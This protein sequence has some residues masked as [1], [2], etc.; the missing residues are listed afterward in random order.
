[1]IRLQKLLAECGIGSRR[2][3]EGFIKEGRIKVGGTLSK[4]GDKATLYDE[5][6]L[7]NTKLLLETK[8]DTKVLIYNKQIKEL[9]SR[10][11]KFHDDTVFDNLPELHQGRWIM[12][13]RL[14]FNSSGLLLFTNDGELANKLM[15][16]SANLER[17]YLVRVFGTLNQ[18]EI[19]E[20]TDGIVIE[21]VKYKAKSVK[22]HQ[23]TTNNTW[24]EVTLMQGKNREI[25]KLFNSQDLTISKLMR[26]SYGPISLPKD[27]KIGS[28]QYLATEKVQRLLKI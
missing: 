11:D 26:I 6:Y 17:K 14:D 9:C 13:G 27:L 5:I 23:Q 4:L 24:Y 7:D 8:V 21:G 12:V 1:M 16:P 28:C 20:M 15:H 25:R 18:R 19:K 10:K 22:L 3:I 2:E